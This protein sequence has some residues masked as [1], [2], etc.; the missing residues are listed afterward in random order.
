MKLVLWDKETL[1]M[2]FEILESTANISLTLPP[3][4]SRNLAPLLKLT[5]GLFF[6]ALLNI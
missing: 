4:P 5:T 1:L 2:F 6:N 3:S